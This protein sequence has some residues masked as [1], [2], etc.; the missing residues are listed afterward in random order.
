MTRASSVAPGDSSIR[1]TSVSCRSRSRS[2]GRPAPTDAEH[3]GVLDDA[4]CTEGERTGTVAVRVRVALGR[5]AVGRPPRMSDA[6][7]AVHR[8]SS[9]ELAQTGDAFRE[10]AV[11]TPAPFRT[12]TPAESYPRYSVRASPSIR[13]ATAFLGPNISHDS[14]HRSDALRLSS[15]NGSPVIA[16]PNRSELGQRTVAC[17]ER[18]SGSGRK[19][20]SAPVA[21][22]PPGGGGRARALDPLVG[23]GPTILATHTR[24]SQIT[25]STSKFEARATSTPAI[26]GY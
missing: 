26:S 1:W 19:R 12:A 5:R 18:R 20:P 17:A 11:S 10:L 25:P 3:V 22:P 9:E 6:A 23:A 16:R 7:A 14:A 21:L 8:R 13:T 2:D 4:L 24:R 15:S